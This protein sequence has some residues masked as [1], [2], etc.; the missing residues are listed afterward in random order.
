MSSQ[1]LVAKIVKFILCQQIIRGHFW[2]VG[3]QTAAGWSFVSSSSSSVLYFD[4]CGYSLWPLYLGHISGTLVFRYA[5]LYAISLRIWED[6]HGWTDGAISQVSEFIYQGNSARDAA[7]VYHSLTCG[8]SSALQSFMLLIHWCGGFYA[9]NDYGIHQ[10][11]KCALV[12]L[13]CTVAVLLTIFPR[14]HTD[15]LTGN[16]DYHGKDK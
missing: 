6:C 15:S 10:T 5:V 4:S 8:G 12:L 1:R 11:S 13:R 7:M 9:V 2:L 14:A 16:C 3:I